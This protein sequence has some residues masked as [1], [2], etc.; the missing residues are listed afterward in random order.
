MAVPPIAP[1]G[2]HHVA[3]QCRDL[4]VMERFYARVLRLRV[5]RR[6]PAQPDDPLGGDRSVWFA[7]GTGVL[8]LERCTGDV[9]AL[10]WQSDRPGMHLLALSIF[11][12][13]R[14]VW[15]SYLAE[16]GVEV[17]YASPWTLYVRD[18]EGNRIG[19]SHFPD[20]VPA[21]SPGE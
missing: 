2:M 15:R 9:E 8:A 14:E 11:R 17:V 5:V 3:I 1:Q 10:P 6:W 16:Q 18:P 19:L 20:A 7:L 13:G 4:V 21:E 12:H